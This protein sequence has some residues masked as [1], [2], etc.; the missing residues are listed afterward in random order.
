VT[1]RLEGGPYDQRPI[2]IERDTD[3]LR[4][5]PPVDDGGYP[6]RWYIYR[7]TTKQD[8]NGVPIFIFY[9]QTDEDDD[10]GPSLEDLAGN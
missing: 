7:R 4:L 9:W 8:E 10:D 6:H 5:G 3:V 1:V 2:E